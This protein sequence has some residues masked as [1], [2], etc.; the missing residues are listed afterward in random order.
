MKTERL[1]I[2]ISTDT[3]QALKDEAYKRD[4]SVAVVVRDALEEYLKNKNLVA[5]P[6]KA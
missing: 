1:H 4:V 3:R 6:T 5:E 2:K